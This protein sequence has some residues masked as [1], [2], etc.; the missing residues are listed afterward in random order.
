[1]FTDALSFV[2]DY[3]EE[4]SKEL[5]Q[6]S[7]PLSKT[8]SHWLSF[9]LTGMLLTGALC[10]RRLAQTSAGAYGVTALSENV[11]LVVA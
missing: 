2:V 6:K 9:C 5:R 1:M 7:R 4:L 8:Q 3:V 11:K 10:W